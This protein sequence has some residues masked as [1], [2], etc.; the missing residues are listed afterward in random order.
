MGMAYDAATGR[1]VLFD[2]VPIAGDTWTWD[3]T[4]WTQE[5]PAHSPAA[6]Y[7]PGMAYDAATGQVVLFGG[8]NGKYLGDTWTWTDSDWTQRPAGSI[9]LSVQ[10]GPPDTVVS[11]QGWGFLGHE[12]VRVAFVDSVDGNTL[13]VRVTADA[14]GAFTKPVTIPAGATSGLQHLQ[15]KGVTSGRIAKR[16]FTVT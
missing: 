2:G 14:T 12:R 6:R 16:S 8:G 15:A 5:S 9:R 11:V 3:G 7:S 13:L 4:D 1:V 10:S